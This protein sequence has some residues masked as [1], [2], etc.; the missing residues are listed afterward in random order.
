MNLRRSTKFIAAAAIAI[1]GV[2]VLAAC[3]WSVN[4]P[5]K[6]NKDPHLDQ[7]VLPEG[8]SIEV[9]AENVVNA[10]QMCLGDN[11]TL[12]VSTRSEGK[13]YAIVDKDGDHKADKMYTLME[14]R[15][16][17]NGV[18]FKDGSLY[19]AE[20]STISRL[21]DIENNLDNP[22][23]RVIV[24]DQFPSKSHHGWKYLGFGPDGKLYVPVGAPC[25][26]CK[27]EDERF[28]SI[29]TMNQDG[30]DVKVFAHGV[31]NSVGFDWHPETGELWFTENGR[32]MLGDDIPADELNHAPKAGLH[33]GYPYCHQGDLQDP[34][35]GDQGECA[36]YTAPAQK[37]GPHVAAIGMTFY[38]GDQFPD[39]YKNQV[40]IAEHGSWNRSKPIGYRI[41]LVELKDNKA[42][43]YSTFIEGWL[44]DEDAWGRPADVLNLPDGS[45]LISDDKANM[46]YRVSYSKP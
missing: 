28:A 42:V 5:A 33:F 6:G 10:R 9:F 45:I 21:D 19:V 36:S 3:K 29:C 41:S 32:D 35:F 37:L 26:I 22:P 23:K 18:A 38:S 14:G 39:N 12:F 34:K 11:G 46:I 2:T 27:S 31:R 8:F 13:V 15:Y 16:M 24:N 4:L 25:N 20:V 7:L 30:S 40:L 44:N 43:K 1:A 17:P